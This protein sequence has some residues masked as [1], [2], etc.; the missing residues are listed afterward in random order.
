MLGAFQSVD[1]ENNL[2]I[3]EPSKPQ[4]AREALYS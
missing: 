1:D 4:S 2:A 3:T